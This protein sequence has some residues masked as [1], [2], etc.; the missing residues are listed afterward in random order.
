MLAA[1]T[2]VKG[3]CHIKRAALEHGAPVSSRPSVA[4]N[5]P[6]TSLSQHSVSSH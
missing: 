1:M 5:S 2:A 3:G 6:S 4:E